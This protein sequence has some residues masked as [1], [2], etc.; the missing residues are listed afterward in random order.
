MSRPL[1]LDINY[2]LYRLQEC[3]KPEKKYTATFNLDFEIRTK[4]N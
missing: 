3:K 2:K 1:T 4:F